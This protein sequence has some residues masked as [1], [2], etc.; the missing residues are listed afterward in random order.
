MRLNG[1]WLKSGSPAR[2]GAIPF[3]AV[4]IVFFVALIVTRLG[5][6]VDWGAVATV[7]GDGRSGRS[8]RGMEGRCNELSNRPGCTPG[9]CSLHASRG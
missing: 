1:R 8:R 3:L 6:D 2:E 4:V 9:A 5:D 7:A